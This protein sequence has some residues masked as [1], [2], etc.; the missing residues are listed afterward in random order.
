MKVTVWTERFDEGHD[1]AVKAHYP[2]GIHETI[3]AGIR[4]RLG[5]DWEIATSSLDEPENGLSAELLDSTD[6]L[7]WWAHLRHDLVADDAADRVVQRVLK[8]MGL[9]ALHSALE[10]KPFVSLMGPSCSAAR[11][12]RGD[13]REVVWTVSPSHPIAQGIDPLFIIPAEEMYCEYFDIPKP[14]DLVFISTFSGGEV[15]RSGCCFHRGN[16][17]VFYFRPGHETHP[18]FHHD[19][20]QQV[21]ANAVRWAHVPTAALDSFYAADVAAKEGPLGWFDTLRR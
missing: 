9:V 1:D 10:C 8:G 3:A 17:R 2:S 5:S 15:F 11:W 20:V 19:V 4:T 13:D 16:G 21:I 6:V 14:D 7:V 12:R 18:T